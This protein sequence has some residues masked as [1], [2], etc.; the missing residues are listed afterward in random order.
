MKFKENIYTCNGIISRLNELYKK[1]LEI[2]K[3]ESDQVRE[4]LRVADDHLG[5]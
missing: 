2:I 5:G 3:L 1:R 4:S